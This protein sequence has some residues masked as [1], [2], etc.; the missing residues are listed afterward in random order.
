[1]KRK[2]LSVLLALT[3]L[4]QSAYAG[5][6]NDHITS[7]LGATGNEIGVSFDGLVDNGVVKLNNAINT[8]IATTAKEAGSGTYA[9][10]TNSAAPLS[11]R[12]GFDYKVT[13]NLDDVKSSFSQFY[14]WTIAS[15]TANGTDVATLTDRFTNASVS[16]NFTVTVTYDSRLDRGANEFVFGQEGLADPEIFELVTPIDYSTNPVLVNF[17]VK[18]NIKVSDIKT[19]VD[20]ANTVFNNLYVT[21]SGVN[22]N[23]T[24][25][26]LSV[27]AQLTAAEVVL[28]AADGEFGRLTFGSDS[29]TVYVSKPSSGSSSS[30][31]ISY[32]K[33]TPTPTAEPTATPSVAIVVDGEETSVALT[34]EGGKMY[35]DVNTLPVPEKEGF[36]FDGWFTEPYFITKAEG[37]I[38]VTEELKLYPKYVNLVAPADLISE[39]HSAYIV[40]YTDGEAK[41]L[42]NITREEVAAIF[43]RLLTP[44]KRAEIETTEHNFPD[45]SDD[46]WSVEEIATLAN[47]GYIVGD[48]NG[49]F[50]PNAPITRASFV[51][52]AAQF[53]PDVEVPDVSYFSDIEGHWAEDNIKKAAYACYWIFGY[54]D[55]TFRPNDYITR[56]EAMAI[57]NRMLVRYADTS[58]EYAK[59]WPD[60]PEDAW[61]YGP[62]I[63]ATTNH[64]YERTENGWQE[65]WTAE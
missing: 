26:S 59:D 4:G 30:G 48:E 21:L 12:N 11:T 56:A 62:V 53:V 3:M 8:T 60:V 2:I 42:N 43:Y 45:V 5:V 34:E 55:G 14:D 41:P 63:E 32:P 23:T 6:L 54:E 29:S 44:E 58:S 20:G 15:I 28:T 16:G 65:V 18:E 37:K 7:F 27:S 9:E 22:T 31:G 19:N 24:N 36:A 57:I 1:M 64:T 33:P 13:L 25:S 47:G 10:Y 17:K 38:E 40:G 49:N 52:I 51:T 35:L 61:Y 46:K 39:D 50:N